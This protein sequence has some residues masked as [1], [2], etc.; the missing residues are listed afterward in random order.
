MLPS[1]T[2]RSSRPGR[3]LR[4]VHPLLTVFHDLADRRFAAA[5]GSVEVLPPVGPGVDAVFCA[6][7][8]AYLCTASP[9]D[10]LGVDGFGG[11]LQPRVLQA[12]AGPAGEIGVIDVTLVRRGEGGESALSERHDLGH[13]PRVRHAQSLRH[14]VRVF[15][16][17]RGVVT[18]GLGLAG[19]QELSI[20]GIG[21]GRSLLAE[22]LR[23]TDGWLFAAVS[24]GNARSLRLF[25]SVGFAPIGSEVII[26][27]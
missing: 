11:A 18:I 26:R 8:R 15:G 1:P 9:L 23:L 25:L 12:L 10:G 20:E 3:N 27:R 4:L 24:P 14:D 16:D 21:C 2:P 5:D 7:G 6:T 19:R 13:H 22:A 17:E